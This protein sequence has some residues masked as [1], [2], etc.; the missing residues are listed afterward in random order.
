VTP[1]NNPA[2]VR[3][4]EQSGSKVD[5]RPNAAALILT[6]KAADLSQAELASLARCSP[7]FIGFLE[8]G[9]RDKVTVVLAAAIAATLGV[10]IGDLFTPV[11]P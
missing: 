10:E 4:R 3:R 1:S 9:R 7:A 6:R 2:V 5:W 8:T 11:E